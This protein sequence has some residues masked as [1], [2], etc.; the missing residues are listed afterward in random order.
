MYANIDEVLGWEP[1]SAEAA[2]TD[3]VEPRERAEQKP[4]A[5]AQR[6]AMMTAL[7]EALIEVGDLPETV[8]DTADQLVRALLH[9][10]RSLK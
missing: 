1:G 4:G 5:S 7:S 10:L 2:A 8:V 6:M 3:G 9:N